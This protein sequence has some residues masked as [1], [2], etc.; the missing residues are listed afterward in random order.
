MRLG[1]V[2]LTFEPGETVLDTLKALLESDRQPD[3]LVVADNCSAPS[4]LEAMRHGYPDVE[5]LPMASN[6]GYGPSMNSAA[7]ALMAQDCEQL[8]FLTQETVLAADAIDKL[9]LALSMQPGVVGPL[10][11]RR[12]KPDQVWSSGGRLAGIRRVP[13]HIDSGHPR[14]ISKDSASVQWLDGACLL[15]TATIFDRLGGFRTDLFLYLEDVDYCLR[16]AGS[17]AGVTCVRS[18]VAWQEPSMTPPYLAARNRAL[19][20]GRAGVSLDLALHTVADPLRGRPRRTS[21]LGRAGLAD[22]R[23]GRLDRELALERP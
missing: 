8:L 10:L 5:I 11:C 12:S 2:V 9:E 21:V 13:R 17:G 20:L 23:T 18:A 6:D 4:T 14:T 15:T 16:V 22:A 19:V 1:V 3:T 7:T